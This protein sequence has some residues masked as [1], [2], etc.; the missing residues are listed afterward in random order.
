M[1]YN[2]RIDVG[3]NPGGGTFYEVNDALQYG[4]I[5]YSIYP[6]LSVDFHYPCAEGP[7][8][9]EV[10]GRKGMQRLYGPKDTIR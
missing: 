2:P 8:T 10:A 4:S 3:Q 1:H 6:S 5:G 7:R 9:Y